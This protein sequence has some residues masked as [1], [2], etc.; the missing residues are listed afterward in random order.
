MIDVKAR[1]Q[2]TTKL[3]IW[4]K[5]DKLSTIVTKENSKLQKSLINQMV[6]KPFLMQQDKMFHIKLTSFLL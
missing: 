4:N 1:F 5:K 6:C 3:L 2:I